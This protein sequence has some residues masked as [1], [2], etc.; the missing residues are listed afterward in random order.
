MAIP[1]RNL[2]AIKGSN[3]QIGEALEDI[4]TYLTNMGQNLAL[5]PSGKPATPPP[6]NSVKIATADGLHQVSITDN[7]P[8][9]RPIQ[10]FAEYSPK[11]DFQNSTVV[12]MGPSRNATVPL[13][14]KALYWRAY[15]QYTNGGPASTPV[16]H[17]NGV[18]ATLVSQGKAGLQYDGPPIQTSSGAGINTNPAGGEGAGKFPYSQTT[19]GLPPK[20][21]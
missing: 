4:Q 18:K 17:G 6:I 20:L 11:P 21:S 14:N 7:N 10:Y 15:S 5:D 16:V 3:R 13:G 2:Q 19:N 9:Y 8:I 1:V 12:P